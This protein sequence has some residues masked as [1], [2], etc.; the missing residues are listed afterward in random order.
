MSVKINCLELENVKRIKAVKIEPTANGMTVIGGKNGQGK[1][2]VLDSI[3]WLFCGD[4][5]RPS[6]ANREGSYSSPYLR[7]ELSN[8]IVVERKGE[9]SSLKVTSP[10]GSKAGQQ[11]L[12]SFI[13]E[14]ALNLPKFLNST[15]KEKANELLKIIGVSEQLAN[16]EFREKNIYNERYTIGR[17]AEQKKKFADELIYHEGIPDV[18]VSASTL[19]KQQQEILAKN[20]ENA[21]KRLKVKEL[22]QIKQNLEKEFAEISSKLSTIN[23]DLEIAKLSAEN[24]IDL[25]TAELENNISNIDALNIKIRQNLDKERANMEAEEMSR[26]YADLTEELENIRNEK[27]KLFEGARLPLPGLA[28]EDGELTYFGNKWDCLSGAQ[29]LKV[30]TAIV[31]ELNKDCGFVLLDGLEALDVDSLA[32]FGTWLE[33]EG[34]QAICT[35]VATDDT[36][37]IIIEEGTIVE[38]ESKKTSWKEGEF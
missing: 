16:I 20:G 15:N 22:E 25:S 8:G 17:I 33:S 3:A 14:L 4:K 35:R 26:K 13:E 5:Y 21:Q 36:C 23:A 9:N 31:R 27:I 7:A 24:L 1:T 12:N 10:D 37:S 34:L 18:P 29:Q 28:V 11:L 38:N 30:A 32:E 2:S 6:K 19:I